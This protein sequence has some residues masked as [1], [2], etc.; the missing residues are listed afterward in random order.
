[1]AETKLNPTCTF[2]I[3]SDDC[4]EKALL[5]NVSSNPR[6]RL[7]IHP[8]KQYLQDFSRC[9]CALIFVFA[10]PQTTLWSKALLHVALLMQLDARFAGDLS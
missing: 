5:V 3:Q 9:K 8:H 7:L 4:A 2:D 1:M 6:V 10:V